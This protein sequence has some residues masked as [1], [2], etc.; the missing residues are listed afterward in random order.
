MIH[1][2]L[3]PIA[4]SNYSE[5]ILK[6]SAGLAKAFGAKLLIVNVINERD[7]E[8]I[9]KIS[10]FGY[11][12]DAEHYLQT[13]QKE[14]REKMAVLLEK[15]ELSADTVTFSFQ[16]GNPA[17]KLLQMVVE[18][19]VDTVV[20][21]MRDRDI[22]T[23]FTGSVAERMFQR[24][25]TTLISY[26]DKEIATQLRKRIKPAASAHDPDRRA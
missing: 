12:V 21:G 1:K 20:M 13:M 8:S 3:V 4:F 26:R 22:S 10:S 5:G 25:P 24:C 11:N 16:I 18:E 19:N 17:E 23:L 7:L 2:I 14:R 9:Q 15:A 6:Y